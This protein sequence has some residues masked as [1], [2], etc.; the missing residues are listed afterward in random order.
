MGTALALSSPSSLL[1]IL[2]AIFIGIVIYWATNRFTYIMNV[3]V[4]AVARSIIPILTTL[5]FAGMIGLSIEVGMGAI[6]GS[7]LIMCIPNFILGLAVIKIIE[8]IVDWF[9]S[10]TI[11]Y[12][13]VSFTIIDSILSGLLV[14]FLG[15]FIK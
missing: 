12:F 14:A 2:N 15:L 10:D 8:K 5:I 3:I 6:L 4:Y 7:M 1:S 11:I 13:I 9:S